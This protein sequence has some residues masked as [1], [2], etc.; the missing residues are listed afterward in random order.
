MAKI[1]NI[2]GKL[3]DKLSATQMRQYLHCRQDMHAWEDYT[4]TLVRNKRTRRQQIRRVVQCTRCES[5]RVEMMTIA[6]GDRI[7][8][9]VYHHSK[10]YRLAKGEKFSAADRAAIRLYRASKS[11]ITVEE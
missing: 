3:P 1:P 8:N 10:G 6:T 11:K 4:Y 9:P 5:L 7:G 2:N